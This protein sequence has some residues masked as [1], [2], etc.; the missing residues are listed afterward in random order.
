MDHQDHD[1][2]F[3]INFGIVLGALMGLALVFVVVARIASA[4]DNKQS[5]EALAMLD[6]RIKPIGHAVTDPSVLLQQQAAK[7]AH[8]PMTGEQVVAKVCSA[9][10]GTGMLGAPK[11]GDKAAW[12]PRKSAAGGIDGLV[13][14]A[15]KGKNQMPP[16]GG[17]AELS[18]A[19][20]KAAIEQMAGK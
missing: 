13:A 4:G 2:V 11:I 1:R 5:G 8:T 9:C 15:G 6:E 12:G 7:P 10:H 19:E 14:S 3:V 17:D 18:D 16:R 20:L